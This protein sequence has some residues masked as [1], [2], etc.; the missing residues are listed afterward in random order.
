MRVELENRGLRLPVA[1]RGLGDWHVGQGADPRAIAV[2]RAAG[3]DLSAHRARQFHD[4]DFARFSTVLAV[5]RA[6]L[7]ELRRR[8][9][10]DTPLPERLLV[11]AGLVSPRAGKEGDIPDPYTGT[12]DDFREVLALIERGVG[13][14]A[15]RLAGQLETRGGRS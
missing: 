5:D 12:A 2:A 9:S 1:S 13:A 15:L 4:D 6:T 14:F 7:V 8:V 3:Y 10:D 11:A